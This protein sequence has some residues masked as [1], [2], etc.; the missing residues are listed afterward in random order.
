M[1]SYIEKTCLNCN[2]KFYIQSY[3]TE[4]AK[5]CSL[6]CKYLQHKGNPKWIKGYHLSISEKKKISE[7]TKKAMENPSIREKIRNAGLGRKN[8][9]ESIKKMI[10]TR[11]KNGFSLSLESR[12]KIGRANK[13]KMLEFYKKGGTVWNKGKK[14]LK[15]AGKN[16]PNWKGGI[17][18]LNAKIRNS[19]EYKL[20]RKSI[21]ERDNY[22]CIWC[23]AKNGKGITIILNADHI[24]PF[25]QFPA[26]RFAIDNGRTL[27]RKCHLLTDTFGGNIIK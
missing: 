14:N 20:W 10:M 18:P 2:K 13:E 21:F 4:T 25:A 24:K 15:G 17:T 27:C 26:L 16:H 8:S 5:F 19:L 3:R 23:G 11:R 6:K 9:P 22:T 1:K 12:K 7:T